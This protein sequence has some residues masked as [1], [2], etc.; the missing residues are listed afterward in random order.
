MERKVYRYRVERS[1][2]GWV[3]VDRDKSKIR[4]HNDVIDTFTSR[5]AARERCQE[6]NGEQ[7]GR[8]EA[9]Q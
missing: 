3:V 2:S 7:D 1:V 9:A 8:T 5:E 6:L 4:M